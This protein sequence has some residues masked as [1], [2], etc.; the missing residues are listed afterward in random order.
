M[1]RVLEWVQCEACG[2]R[3]RWRAEIAGTKIDCACGAEMFVP[4]LD[5]FAGQAPDASRAG[6]TIADPDASAAPLRHGGDD[7]DRFPGELV[8]AD[9]PRFVGARRGL[10]GLGPFH[11]TILWTLGAGVGFVLLAHA[12]IVQWWWYI[13][14]CALWTPYSFVKFWKSSRRWRRGRSFQRAL[15]EELEGPHD[16]DGVPS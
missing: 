1:V 2:R 12:I 15:F 8:G 13:A 10:F 4:E 3:V 6:E 7:P 16:D 14:L 9:A 5:V 11:E